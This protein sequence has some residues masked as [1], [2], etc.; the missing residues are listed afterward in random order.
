MLRDAEVRG[1][2]RVLEAA[3][4]SV[5]YGTVIAPIREHHPGMR[6]RTVTKARNGKLLARV[7]KEMAAPRMTRSARDEVAILAAA[8]R[9][10]RKR[11]LPAD[12]AA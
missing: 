4:A 11:L 8:K 5:H 10:R 6:K 9:T 2:E 7:K 12:A 1:R 3:G